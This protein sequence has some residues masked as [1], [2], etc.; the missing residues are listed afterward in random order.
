[1]LVL[2]LMTLPDAAWAQLFTV[3]FATMNKSFYSYNVVAA[4]ASLNV[5]LE[6]D[7]VYMGVDSDSGFI[8]IG[9]NDELMIKLYAP[10]LS[11]DVDA[12]YGATALAG[13]VPVSG[14]AASVCSYSEWSKSKVKGTLSK[15]IKL[16]DRRLLALDASLAFLDRIRFSNFP[17]PKIAF[18][19]VGFEDDSGY[20]DCTYRSSDD[21]NYASQT[22]A[23]LQLCYTQASACNVY[24]GSSS[25]LGWLYF[26]GTASDPYYGIHVNPTWS[27]SGTRRALDLAN[28]RYFDVAPVAA[29]SDIYA[30]QVINSTSCPR[31]EMDDV[32]LRTGSALLFHLN[33][34]GE[35]VRYLSVY[36]LQLESSVAIVL[37]FTEA[38]GSDKLTSLQLTLPRLVESY[39]GNIATSSWV[40]A[41][42]G[43]P[44]NWTVLATQFAY[45]ALS[46]ALSLNATV[47]LPSAAV[48]TTTTAATT[49]MPTLVVYRCERNCAGHGLCVADGMCQCQ[50][51]W[52]NDPNNG[53]VDENELRTAATD[54]TNVVISNVVN[55]SMVANATAESAADN[56][57]ASSAASAG[58]SSA[59]SAP[60]PPAQRMQPGSPDGVDNTVAIAAGAGAGG[61]VCLMLLCL[62]VFCLVKR[63][64]RRAN[65]ESDDETPS[66]IPLTEKKGVTAS[67]GVYASSAGAMQTYVGASNVAG[68]SNSVYKSPSSVEPSGSADYAFMPT[69]E[70]PTTMESGGE[71]YTVPDLKAAV[72]SE[73]SGSDVY[74]VPALPDEA[75][76]QAASSEYAQIEVR[77]SKKGGFKP[78]GVDIEY[79]QFDPNS[80]RFEKYKD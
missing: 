48:T 65:A 68:G 73:G 2:M 62:L 26:G 78:E 30:S 27:L 71:T 7:Q 46:G 24:I 69:T 25:D 34:R 10:S 55:P 47:G 59:D 28:G 60:P 23:D 29:S 12:L 16:L 61:A 1:M 39:A 5:T 17:R 36:S 14:A 67:D 9:S 51:G 63:R 6:V 74:T 15:P 64:R 21:D 66:V 3:A 56:S 35:L 37:N 53:C 52:A 18:S 44:A 8:G 76:S 4:T 41:I 22:F 50:A 57:H 43:A 11:V 42:T 19:V 54:A 33:R 75:V 45:S 80:A 31:F 20:L 72:A 70:L 77:A 40:L 79:D 58:G 32:T 38:L 49:P 13:N